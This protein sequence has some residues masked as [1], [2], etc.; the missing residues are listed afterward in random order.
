MLQK[1]KLTNSFLIWCF[2]LEEIK[3]VKLPEDFIKNRTL[4]PLKRK[5]K[6]NDNKEKN[7]S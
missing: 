1:K 2:I 6:K 3:I 4:L 5:W 7:H